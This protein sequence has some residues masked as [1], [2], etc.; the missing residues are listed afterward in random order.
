[1]VNTRHTRALYKVQEL[2]E[3]AVDPENAEQPQAQAAGERAATEAQIRA[4]Q[5]FRYRLR[6]LASKTLQTEHRHR[7]VSEL[8]AAKTYERH[9]DP[10]YQQVRV[11]VW[12]HGAHNDFDRLLVPNCSSELVEQ[13][14]T[15][16]WWRFNSPYDHKHPHGVDG[17]NDSTRRVVH[18]ATKEGMH[19]L[20]VTQAA[21]QAAPL[22]P[23]VDGAFMTLFR[24]IVHELSRVG[25]RSG[26][27]LRIIGVNK[28]P[29]KV[30]ELLVL[31][32]PDTRT[33][34]MRWEKF[35]I[36]T[37]RNVVPLAY[38]ASNLELICA[39]IIKQHHMFELGRSV[40]DSML[41]PYKAPGRL[42]SGN[43]RGTFLKTQVAATNWVVQIEVESTR[44]HYDVALREVQLEEQRLAWAKTCLDEARSFDEAYGSLPKK[45]RKVASKKRK[46]ER[47][48]VQAVKDRQMK[49]AVASVSKIRHLEEQILSIDAESALARERTLR[50]AEKAKQEEGTN[51]LLARNYYQSAAALPCCAV[52]VITLVGL[53]SEADTGD[54]RAIR[55]AWLS[56]SRGC[57]TNT[58]P[59]STQDARS[60][61]LRRLLALYVPTRS[62]KK[63]ARKLPARATANLRYRPTVAFDQGPMP[64]A[65]GV[66]AMLVAGSRDDSGDEDA[67]RLKKVYATLPP[68]IAFATRY[69]KIYVHVIVEMSPRSIGV[70][71]ILSLWHLLYV[72]FQ[73]SRAASIIAN[74]WRAFLSRRELQIRATAARSAAEAAASIL[75]QTRFRVLLARKRVTLRKRQI[76]EEKIRAK[77]EAEKEAMRKKRELQQAKKRAAAVA[78]QKR[79]DEMLAKEAVEKKRRGW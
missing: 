76:A 45:L 70:S 15:G 37:R 63:G 58:K 71:D 72:E 66:D 57:N 43:G 23:E 38:I 62:H 69:H 74:A 27:G 61:L 21:K 68:R 5:K 35:D 60:D 40:Q 20:I 49:I 32:V 67:T 65:T 79:R 26:S 7:I 44:P 13:K 78:M 2:V 25:A 47:K 36:P 4:I 3:G 34:L 48:R 77:R 33:A 51:A 54:A 52:G 55:S 9:L 1:M 50:I 64:S 6:E 14:S 75:V 28:S 46:L 41:V 18:R 16:Q 12:E 24:R 73:V 22:N 8:A 17:Q 59:V 11:H 31:A 30:D 53:F 19:S 56:R 42:S 29:R 10:S 39:A